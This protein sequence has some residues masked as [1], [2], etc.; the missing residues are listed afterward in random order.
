MIP[1]VRSPANF[2]P[3]PSID[4]QLKPDWEYREQTRSFAS[5]KG[6]DFDIPKSFPKQA[7]FVCKGAALGS[8]KA[9]KF[10][11]PERELRRHFV[12]ILPKGASAT[13]WL[14]VVR[15]WPM[16]VRAELPPQ[17]SLPGGS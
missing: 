11:A 13:E 9:R 5:A 12:I 3:L 14:E 6:E 16:V 15:S 17:V 1:A 7:Q 2:K 10:S 8:G 4:V